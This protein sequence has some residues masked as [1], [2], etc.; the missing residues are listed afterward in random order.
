MDTIFLKIADMIERRET[1][2]KE[3]ASNLATTQSNLSKIIRG[4]TEPSKPLIKLANI[5]Y[6]EERAPHKNPRIEKINQLLEGMEEQGIDRIFDNVQRE[7]QFQEL[8]KERQEK[9]ATAFNE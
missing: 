6:G 7:K 5:I 9:S 3:V 1:N 2:Q 4:E 8:M